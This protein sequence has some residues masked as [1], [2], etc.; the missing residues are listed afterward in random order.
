MHYVYILKSKKNGSIYIG[1]A[2]NVLERLKKH[3]AGMNKYTKKF[4]P[5]VLIYFEGYFSKEDAIKREHNLKY[6][7]NAIAQLKKRAEN[8]FNDA[9]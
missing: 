3:N 5:W 6:R 1:Y 8:S 7:G 2:V 9:Q 4:T